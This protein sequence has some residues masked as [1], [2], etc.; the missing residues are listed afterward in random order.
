MY[1]PLWLQYPGISGGCDSSVSA[2]GLRDLKKMA[3]LK[4]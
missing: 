1:P 3:G 4:N 2:A